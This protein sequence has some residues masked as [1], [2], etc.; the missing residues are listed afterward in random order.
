MFFCRPLAT[1]KGTNTLRLQSDME[2]DF[3]KSL[4][5]QIKNSSYSWRLHDLY[6]VP[7]CSPECPICKLYVEHL[8]LAYAGLPDDG[9]GCQSLSDEDEEM[10]DDPDSDSG[11]VCGWV[12]PRESAFAPRNGDMEDDA[13]EDVATELSATM[14]TIYMLQSAMG[15]VETS[16]YFK[17]DPA[18]LGRAQKDLA[19]IMTKISEVEREQDEIRSRTFVVEHEIEKIQALRDE[20]YAKLQALDP[21]YQRK[22]QAA[23]LAAP[24]DHLTIATTARSEPPNQVDAK[25]MDSNI[26]ELVRRTADVSVQDGRLQSCSRISQAG[27]KPHEQVAHQKIPA[28]TASPEH[29]AG[30]IQANKCSN[31]K[32]VPAC[33][34]HWTVDLRDARGHQAMMTMVPP[35]RHRRSKA[36]RTWRRNCFLAILRI[37]IIP[38]E[39]AAII[40]RTSTPVVPVALSAVNFGEDVDQ[41]QDDDVARHLASKGLT[42]AIADDCG[43]F[44][45]KF[46]EA[47]ITSSTSR[48]DK[49]TLIQLLARARDTMVSKPSG[50]L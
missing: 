14:H 43:Q 41:L 4:A 49:E 7:L 44:C 9:Q 24:S 35:A 19:D 38:G 11:S 15:R 12:P 34:P 36:A 8:S 47:E 46:V 2:K 16:D 17:T 5:K 45:Q 42:A 37:L 29:L 32:G 28:A 20:T 25:G 1:I 10:S 3:E 22:R 6:N 40:Q 21:T 18:A 31:V 33:G 26:V 23:D 39:Y 27:D 30:W 48:Y 13:D 50:V